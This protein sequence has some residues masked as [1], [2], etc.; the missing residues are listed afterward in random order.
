MSRFTTSAP[1]SRRE[2]IRDAVTTL[3]GRRHRDTDA[4]TVLSRDAMQGIADRALKRSTADGCE[5]TVTSTVAGNTRFAANQLA[6]AGDVTDTTVTV[7]TSFGPKH[8]IV[9]IND[10]SDD[11]IAAAVAR[12]EVLAKLAPDDPDAMPPVGPQQYPSVDAYFEGTASVTPEQRARAALTALQPA[13]AS[14]GAEASV[15]AGYIIV[16]SR[17]TLLTN[18]TGLSAYHRDTDANYTLTVRTADGTGSGWAGADER[19]W[20]KIDAGAIATHALEKARRSRDAVAVEPGRYTV[21]L[22]PQ[23]V[24]DLVQLLN[25]FLDARQADEGRSPFTSSSGGSK[26]GQKVADSSVTLF[27]DPAD[28][29]LL[30]APFDGEGYPLTRQVWIDKGVLANLSYSRFWAK[31]QNKPFSG[32]RNSIKLA[33]GSSTLDDM[34]KGTERG[35]LVTRLWY[36]RPVDPRTALFTGLTRDGT[37]LIEHGAVTHPVKNFRFNDSPIF[38]LNNVEAMS[39]PVRLAGTEAGGD[40]AMPAV[41]AHD[42]NFTS[43]SDAV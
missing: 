40:V 32:I 15:A 17:A 20:G 24:G 21:V 7:N 39:A 16:V 33:G 12:S 8:A 41:K 18:K 19:D 14:S 13:R 1:L 11:A 3:G 10:T 43:L 4:F 38:L 34:I 31:K 28:P 23:A 25:F 37:Y 6:T 42:F 27:S 5:I 35:I 26:V 29:Q 30:A 2:V 22:E 9:Q 36:L